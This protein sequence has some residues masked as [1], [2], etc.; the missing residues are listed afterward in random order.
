MPVSWPLWG[1]L[2]CEN[3][4]GSTS[5]LLCSR[6]SS[7]WSNHVWNS[8]AYLPLLLGVSTVQPSEGSGP[9]AAQQDLED[10]AGGRRWQ[11]GVE[12]S[13]TP[14]LGGGSPPAVPIWG[15]KRPRGSSIS[16]R[17]S[18]GPEWPMAAAEQKHSLPLLQHQWPSTLN[19]FS[20]KE[21]YGQWTQPL[22]PWFKLHTSFLM[23]SVK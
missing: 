11:L 8:H 13:V 20:G 4:Q 21:V 15:E 14:A 12:G 3:V 23:F 16:S 17:S 22:E 7:R 19:Y 9:V 6:Y 2:L 18:L 5:T 10:G 1:E